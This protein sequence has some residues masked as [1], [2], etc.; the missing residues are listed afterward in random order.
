MQNSGMTSTMACHFLEQLCHPNSHYLVQIHENNLHW[1]LWVV[2]FP[3][4]I[5]KDWCME[6]YAVPIYSF[7]V[8]ETD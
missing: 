3:N 6:I 8:S 5:R 2:Q 1:N 4:C 7:M